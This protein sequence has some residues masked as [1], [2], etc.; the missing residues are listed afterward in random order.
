M[1][2]KNSRV[3]PL[4]MDELN[5]QGMLLVMVTAM[6]AA[7]L[8]FLGSFLLGVTSRAKVVAAYEITYQ[9]RYAAESALEVVKNNIKT[10]AYNV[11]GN[12]W[13]TNN[14]SA[15]GYLAINDLMIGTIP[16]DVTITTLGTG[17]HRVAATAQSGYTNSSVILECRG[18]DSF[19]RYMF[20]ISLDDINIGTSTVHGDVHANRKVN[21]YYGGAMMYDDVTAVD[22]IGYYSGASAANTTFYGE[23]N[24]YAATVPWPST[25]EIAT[26][27]TSTSGVY[28][29][30]NSSS[31]Y[32]GFGAFNT[33]I[34]FL[35]N[36][37]KITAK[38]ISDGS[39]LKTGTYPLPANNLIFV[40]NNV[41]S[42]KGDINGRVT[43][44]TMSAVNVTGKVRYID[45]E[46]DKAYI[47]KRYGVEVNPDMTGTDA[48]TTANGYTYEANSAYNP[49][50]LST[51]GIMALNDIQITSAAPYN[52]EFH[53]ATFSSTG[54]WYCSLAQQKG[55]LRGLGSQGQKYRGWRY[56]GSGYG[57]AK[58]GE[59]IYD[60]ALLNNPPAYYLQVDTPVFGAWFR[61]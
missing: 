8:L 39:T 54:K 1:M 27:Q 7:M 40:Q 6:I 28:D 37:V 4:K 30:S 5:Q 36:Q 33:E 48:W 11:N 29:V 21:F 61:N 43:V 55:N 58:S 22:G 3:I 17:W 20:M 15:G 50:V 26:L 57:W 32:A 35:G 25:S 49:S 38:K 18:R 14:S 45:N 31:E 41:T 9:A 46:G 13:L 24:G 19:S 59:Y 2:N 44:A 51:V 12:I 52:M 34:E 42:L 47:L 16:V 60:S 10:S 53:G 23:V 56:N